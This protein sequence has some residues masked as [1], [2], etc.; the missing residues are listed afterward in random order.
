VCEGARGEKG[1]GRGLGVNDEKC[2][3]KY[4]YAFTSQYGNSENLPL[5]SEAGKSH[6]RDHL[7]VT[8]WPYTRC[9]IQDVL[10]CFLCVQVP[11]H[12]KII[13][14]WFRCVQVPL[15]IT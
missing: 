13:L 14:D 5:V 7:N 9:P 11:F 3:T 2:D 10:V 4:I 1:G 15:V 6:L 12:L 8:K